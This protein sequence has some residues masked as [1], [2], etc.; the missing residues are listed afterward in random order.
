[1]N[2]T[3]TLPTAS[4]SM[5]AGGAPAGKSATSAHAHLAT[6]ETMQSRFAFRLASRLTEGSQALSPEINERLRFARE[7]ALE[8]ARAMRPVGAFA[9]VG[10]TAGGAAVLGRGG[11]SYR[12]GGWW[13]RL[14]SVLPVLALVAGLVAIE[15]W[16][17]NAQ[18]S[19]AADIDAALLSDDLPPTAYSDAGFVEYLKNPDQ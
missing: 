19:V 15:R 10:V 6:A 2:Q 7:Q 18:A 16:Q 9:R 4:S 5:H 14:A 12:A 3:T 8:R 17:D 1:M 11:G 13:F